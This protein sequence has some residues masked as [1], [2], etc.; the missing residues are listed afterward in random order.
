MKSGRRIVGYFLCIAVGITLLVLGAMGIVDSFWSGMGTALVL[1]SVLFLIRW[2][3]YR[4]NEAY[5]EKIETEAS[6]ERNRFL[7]DRAWAWTGYLFVLIACV[8]AIAFRVMGEELISSVASY[9][10]CL[11]VVLY[12]GTYLILRRK[13]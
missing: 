5:R 1:V 6:D 4:K 12:W 13:Y 7:R 11:M 10:V 3:R 8:C 2:I 9:A